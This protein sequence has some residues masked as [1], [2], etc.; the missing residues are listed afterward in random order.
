MFSGF[1]FKIRNVYYAVLGRWHSQ[2]STCCS[3]MKVG[4][5]AGTL[6]TLVVLALVVRGGRFLELSAS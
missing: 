3:N 2:S 1:L 4:S 5:P 6:V